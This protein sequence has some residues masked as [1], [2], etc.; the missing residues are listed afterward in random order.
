MV[1]SGP[2]MPL[3]LAV[4]PDRKQAEAVAALARGVL[5]SEVIVTDSA[6]AALAVL[7]RRVPDLL[8]TSL[9]LPPKDEA[10]IADRL[11]ALDANGTSVQ[12]LVIPMLASSGKRSQESKK[13]VNRLW[14]SK[15]KASAPDGC[16]PEVFA[17][18]ISEYLRRAATEEP[19]RGRQLPNL[20]IEQTP[21]LGAA[22]AHVPEEPSRTNDVGRESQFRDPPQTDPPRT[23]QRAEHPPTDRRL[24]EP[25]GAELHDTPPPGAKPLIQNEVRSNTPPNAESLILQPLPQA[26]PIPLSPIQS[27]LIQPPPLQA[28]LHPPLVQPPLAQVPPAQSAPRP[29]GPEAQAQKR[30][31]AP[32][33]AHHP[34]Q[35]TAAGEPPP[36][37]ARPADALRAEPPPQVAT[38]RAVPP[39]V[40][41]GK[42]AQGAP[43]RPVPGSAFRASANPTGPAQG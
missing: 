5:R 15:A 7:A 9:L 22:P 20:E 21:V 23:D 12:T 41:A 8:L 33:P 39:F 2:V 24:T 32:K 31:T 35:K 26:P 27:S 10:K 3:I 37:G 25:I 30:R 4:E 19:Q 18:Q 17:S 6:D 29:E 43:V 11:R 38:P 36:Y 16:A 1:R 28:P 40:A 34:E 13:N 14:K 42:P